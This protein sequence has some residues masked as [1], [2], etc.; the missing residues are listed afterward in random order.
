M[1]PFLPLFT[2]CLLQFACQ[3][4]EET[5]GNDE[6]R[7]NAPKPKKELLKIEVQPY[8]HREHWSFC[9][10]AQANQYTMQLGENE[11]HFDRINFISHELEGANC[12]TIYNL[13]GHKFDALVEV[14]H[15]YSDKSADH[16]MHA[17]ITIDYPGQDSVYKGEAKL[18]NDIH[19]LSQ[20]PSYHE[21]K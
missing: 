20:I 15:Q 10:D 16:S 19:P 2:F 1:R 12:I 18:I 5:K 13:L 11:F 8:I 14:T 21:Q 6:S 7:K 4:D 9:T 3:P 17:K